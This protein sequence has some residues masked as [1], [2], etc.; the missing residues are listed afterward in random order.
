MKTKTTSI[1]LSETL[2]N[3]INKFKKDNGFNSKSE[4]IR[5]CLINIITSSK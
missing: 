5:Y 1:R 2:E 4:V 3:Q